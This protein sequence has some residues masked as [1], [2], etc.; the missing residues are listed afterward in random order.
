MV[1][2]T[3]PADLTKM[4]VN[5][6]GPFVINVEERK[7]CQIILEGDKYPVKYPV[8]DILKSGKAGE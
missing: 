5:L 3:V 4:T 2:V 6:Q 1:T 7:A 8:Y